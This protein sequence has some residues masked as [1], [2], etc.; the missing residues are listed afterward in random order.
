MCIFNILRSIHIQEEVVVGVSNCLIAPMHCHLFNITSSGIVTG[1]VIC[2][3]LIPV[4]LNWAWSLSFLK[5]ATVYLISDCEGQQT[6]IFGLYCREE[7]NTQASLPLWGGATHLVSELYSQ[8]VLRFHQ[9]V[10]T[11]E[12]INIMLFM[13]CSKFPN[14]SLGVESALL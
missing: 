14:S 5:A 9:D 1:F 2:P 7:W 10:G 11:W 3:L 4:Y 8:T 6:N 12:H 13:S